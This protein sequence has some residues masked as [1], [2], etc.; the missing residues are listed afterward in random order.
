MRRAIVGIDDI[1]Q[2]V[3]WRE[4]IEEMRQH[5]PCYKIALELGIDDRDVRRYATNEQEPRYSRGKAILDLRDK[6]RISGAPQKPE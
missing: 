4:V 3:D 1:P 5:M 6:L 2:F